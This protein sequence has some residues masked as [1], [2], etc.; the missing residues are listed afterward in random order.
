MLTHSDKFAEELKQ[1]HEAA[2]C[3]SAGDHPVTLLGSRVVVHV[4]DVVG[5][6][7]R[8]VESV[9]IVV[10]D[11]VFHSR[12]TRALLLTQGRWGWLMN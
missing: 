10:D 7:I 1:G 6:D 2:C 12:F 9:A 8:H 11:I 5:I 4:L 3:Q